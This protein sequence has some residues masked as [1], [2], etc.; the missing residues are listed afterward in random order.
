MLQEDVKSMTVNTAMAINVII[1]TM[2]GSPNLAH[3]MAIMMAVTTTAAAAVTH[4]ND[5][6]TAAEVAIR[7]AAS[8]NDL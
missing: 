1:T 2:S 5:I 3:M 7:S 6:G 8:N 4:P